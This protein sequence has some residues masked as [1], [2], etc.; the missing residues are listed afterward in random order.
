VLVIGGEGVFGSRLVTGMLQT[1]TFEIVIAGRDGEKLERSRASLVLS[2]GPDAQQ[3]LTA[4]VMDAAIASAESLAPTS[5]FALLDA[6]GPYQGGNYRLARAAIQAGMHYVDLADARD[7]VSGFA[8][9]DDE[10]RAAGVVALTDASSTPAL[11]N[12]VLDVLTA[13]W[14]RVHRV[15]IAISPGNRPPRGLA[16]IRSILSYAGRPVRVFADGAWGHASGWGMTVR[17]DIPEIGRRW[18]SLSET[19]DLDIVPARF[20]VTDAAVFRAGL[21]LSVLHLGLWAASLPVRF[22]LVGSLAPLARIVRLAAMAFEPFGTDRGGMTVMAIGLDATGARVSGEWHLVADAG[23]GPYLPTLPA[24]A[25]LRALA[26]GRVTRPGASACVGVLT[27]AEMEA[28]FTGRRIRSA[29][30]VKRSRESLYE[31]VLGTGFERLPAAVRRM[32]RPG[33]GMTAAGRS[34]VE[35]ANGFVARLVAAAFCFPPAGE[36][37]ELTVRISPRDDGERWTRDFGGRRF[38]SVLSPAPRLGRMIERFGIFRFELDLPAG[39]AGVLGMPIMGW[40]LGPM[41]LPRFLAPVSIVTEDVDPSGRF[42]FDV[43]LRLPFGLGRLVR[44]RGWLVPR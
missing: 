15:E 6:A 22:G 12:A 14:A 13:G 4:I 1:T 11:S 28:E 21:E 41:P 39:E 10:A 27:L 40:S 5:A 35:G 8:V 9:L 43:E 36:N 38:S 30:E 44:Y 31:R 23:D 17:R 3:R 34:I 24:L 25:V 29:S 19:P 7:F 33:W 37:V 2:G 16:V 18:L 26:D 32:H 20:G 42:H